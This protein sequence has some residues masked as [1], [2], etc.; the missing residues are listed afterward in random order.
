MAEQEAQFFKKRA[1]TEAGVSYSVGAALPVLVSL[2]VGFV[3]A[4]A[5]GDDYADTAWYR[6]LA[7]LVPQVCFAATALIF[8]RR[9]KVPVRSVYCGCKWYYFPVALLMQFGL[10][11]SLS[12]LNNLFVGML[13]SFGYKSSLSALPPLDGWYLLPALLIIAVLPAVFEETLFRGI[14][15]G[16]MAAS[17]WGTAAT[18]FISG[19]LFSLYH[20]NPAQTIYQFLCGVCFAL[21]VVRS[22]SILPSIVAHFANNALIVVLTATGYGVEGGWEMPF[23]WN[24]GLI[25]ASAVCLAAVLA[26]LVFFDK[27][28]QKKGGVKGG[29]AFFFAAAVGIAVCAVQWIAVLVAGFIGG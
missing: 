7:Y 18:V 27:S 2:I 20:G 12:E 28:N 9:S 3:A 19:A 22:G 4:L 23:G 13:E 26:F 11:F 6:F 24:V 16:R 29:K 10:M 15:V 14:L 17:E 5:A 8:F 21:I 1:L 25:A